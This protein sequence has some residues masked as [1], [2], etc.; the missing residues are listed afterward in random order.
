MDSLDPIGLTELGVA[1][2]D[3]GWYEAR[4]VPGGI[5]E[6]VKVVSLMICRD[7]EEVTLLQEH[8]GPSGVTS[9]TFTVHAE[10]IWWMKPSQMPAKDVE[11]FGAAVRVPS[12]DGA[13]DAAWDAVAEHLGLEDQ[14]L[15]DLTAHQADSP[16]YRY[17]VMLVY[18]GLTGQR[19]QNV[20]SRFG[21][22]SVT[23]LA[24]AT[25]L[26]RHNGKLSMDLDRVLKRARIL[27]K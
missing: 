17:W 15:A 11:W 2:R 10:M 13:W 21:Y 16:I 25:T 3:E 1:L 9:Q 22:K 5:A 26:F 8:H 7:H 27:A 20:T 4:I 6:R 23:P 18:S 19:N 12:G 14:E 24:S